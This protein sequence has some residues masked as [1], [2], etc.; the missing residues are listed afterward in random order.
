M[1]SMAQEKSPGSDGLTKE[2]YKY[3]W[4]NIK[5]IFITCVRATERRKEFTLSQ[6]QTVIE[7]IEKKGRD[8]MLIQNWRTI[9]LRNIDYKIVSKAVATFLKSTSFFNNTSAGSMRS[10]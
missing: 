9:S 4:K 2:F 7:L 6:K 3:F 10:K 1:T 8:K 5:D